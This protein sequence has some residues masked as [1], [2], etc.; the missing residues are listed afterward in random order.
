MVA[1]KTILEKIEFLEWKLHGQFE[2]N[3]KYTKNGL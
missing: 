1:P 3:F 2:A